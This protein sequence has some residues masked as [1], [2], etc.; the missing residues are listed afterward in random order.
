MRR[1][2]SKKSDLVAN[3][4]KLKN[5]FRERGSLEDMVNKETKRAFK[6]PLLGCSKSSKRR[7]RGNGLI[8]V[9][10]VVN[11]NPFVSR[12]GKLYLKNFIF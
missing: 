8:E 3:V 9:A 10:P 6:T 12:L 2:R 7:L 4:K 5:W 11:Y 1:I